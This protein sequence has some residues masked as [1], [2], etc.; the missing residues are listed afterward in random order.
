M[1]TLEVE[2]ISEV[3]GA[4][5]LSDLTGFGGPLH[6]LSDILVTVYN[7]GTFFSGGVLPIIRVGSDGSPF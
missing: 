7:I 1:R 4:G 5:I 3:S 6:E 2:E